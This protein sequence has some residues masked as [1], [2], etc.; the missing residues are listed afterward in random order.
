M[1]T[2]FWLLWTAACIVLCSYSIINS[3]RD[4]RQA[5]RRAVPITPLWA[6]LGA[7]AIREPVTVRIVGVWFLAWLFAGF[8]C[9]AMI[10]G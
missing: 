9:A 4:Y 7:E 6:L 1:L 3:W 10:G 8:I 5:M 2:L